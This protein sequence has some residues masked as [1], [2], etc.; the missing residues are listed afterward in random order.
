MANVIAQIATL[1]TA[2]LGKIGGAIVAGATVVS[3]GLGASPVV[4]AAVI[5]GTVAVLTSAITAIVGPM[6]LRRG[7]ERA[8]QLSRIEETLDR[9]DGRAHELGERIARV[10]GAL[11]PQQPPRSGDNQ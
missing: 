3:E 2:T 11:F 5:A 10:E 1:R 7:D 8:Q 9:L 6:I 4:I